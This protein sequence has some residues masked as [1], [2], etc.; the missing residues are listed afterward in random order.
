MEEIN[1]KVNI[2]VVET[3]EIKVKIGSIELGKLLSSLRKSWIAFIQ[4]RFRS[5]E[6]FKDGLKEYH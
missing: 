6:K 1:D 2:G 4:S 3:E 5:H